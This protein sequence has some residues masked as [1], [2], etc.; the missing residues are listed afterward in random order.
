MIKIGT[1]ILSN[2]GNFV[3]QVGQVADIITNRWGTFHLV[4]IGGE[5]VEVMHISEEGYKGI[6]YKIA[7]ESEIARATRYAAALAEHNASQKPD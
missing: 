7:T 4:L 2:H 3:T 6:G 5:F 1:K